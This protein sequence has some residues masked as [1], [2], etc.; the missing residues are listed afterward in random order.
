MI[1]S[2]KLDVNKF[3]FISVQIPINVDNKGGERYNI[4][5]KLRRF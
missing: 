4:V 2:K 1:A 3:F 5:K